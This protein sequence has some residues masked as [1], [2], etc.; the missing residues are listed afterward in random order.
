MVVVCQ[1]TVKLANRHHRTVVC[2]LTLLANDAV[3]IV[4][5]PLSDNTISLQLVIMQQTIYTI[6]QKI[7]K[8][9]KQTPANIYNEEDIQ[10]SECIFAMIP[11]G[12][13]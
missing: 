6:Q 7:Y 12:P 1:G 3:T 8:K 13:K 4:F 2:L 11:E 9:Q 10:F 5:S